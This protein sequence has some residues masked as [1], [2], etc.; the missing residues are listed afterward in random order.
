MIEEY[1]ELKLPMPISIN[2]AYTGKVKRKKSEAYKNWISFAELEM[3]KQTKYSIKW[4]NWLFVEYE[5][6]FSLYTLEWK[7][8]I[9]DTWNFEKVLSDFLADNITGF[10]DHKIKTLL[11]KKVDNEDAFVKVKIKESV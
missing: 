1:I 10:E 11:L 6:N 2:I 7:K 5:F 4:D 9:K 8:R 3:R